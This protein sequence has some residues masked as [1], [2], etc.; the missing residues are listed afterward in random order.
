[1]SV[2][3]SCS[4]ISTAS[5]WTT[6]SSFRLFVAYCEFM[7]C[8]QYFGDLKFYFTLS[9]WKGEN[10]NTFD[11]GSRGTKCFLKSVF[12][13]LVGGLWCFGGNDF[14]MV[15]FGGCFLVFTEGTAS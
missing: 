3:C 15:D 7:L 1:M 5:L 13:S 8:F 9:A 2:A 14:R 11:L 10:K 4:R 12:Y 6:V